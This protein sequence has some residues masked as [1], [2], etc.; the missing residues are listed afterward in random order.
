VLHLSLVEKEIEC[1]ELVFFVCKYI[2]V[3]YAAAFYSM[4]LSEVV[5]LILQL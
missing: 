5:N 1:K 2:E 4:I 3:H